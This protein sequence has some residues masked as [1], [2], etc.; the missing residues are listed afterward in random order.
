M[1]I[2]YMG[3]NLVGHQVLRWLVD[4]G[5]EIVGLVVHPQDKQKFGREILEA[6]SLGENAIFYGD[7]LRTTATLEQIHQLQPDL[8]LSVFFG[9]ILTQGFLE[10]FPRGCL[11]LHP[12]YL[13]YNRGSHPNIWS[14]VDGT[15]AGATI[16]YID[17]GVD[18]GD[19]VGRRLVQVENVDTGESLYHKLEEACLELFIESWPSIKENSVQRIPQELESGTMHR[20]K[21][22]EP[23]DRINLDEKYVA[24]DLLNLLRARTFPP[25]PGAY[26]EQEGTRVYLQL[27]L[28]YEGQS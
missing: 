10:M 11:N 19:I 16:H 20:V 9:Y 27:Q 4:Q 6:G 28:T 12:A 17:P 5:E 3:N 24:R 13:P 25:Y 15:P 1:R 23:I 8:G 14:I 26:F 7:Q 18:T 22:I 21:D 2:L